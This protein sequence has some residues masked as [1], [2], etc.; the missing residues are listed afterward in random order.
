MVRASIRSR[1]RDDRIRK[2]LERLEAGGGS[3]T[4]PLVSKIK[5]EGMELCPDG[6]Y[7]M[8]PALFSVRVTRSRLKWLNLLKPRIEAAIELTVD[9]TEVFEEF[10]KLVESH[11]ML[12]LLADRLES[13]Q[14]LKLVHIDAS[15]VSGGNT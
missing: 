3:M 9:R 13:K 15:M 14:E 6:R 2:A 5:R 8:Y 12:E 11:G 10:F 1:W 7:R 4:N